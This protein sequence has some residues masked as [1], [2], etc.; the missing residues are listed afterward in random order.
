MTNVS[1]HAPSGQESGGGNLVEMKR[2]ELMEV[3]GGWF[4]SMLWP[5]GLRFSAEMTIGLVDEIREC[6]C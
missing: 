2:E 4:R 3:E 1:L 5:L 6:D